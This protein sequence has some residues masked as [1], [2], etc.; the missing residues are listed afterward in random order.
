M[1]PS[2]LRVE[3]Y[4]FGPFRLDLVARRLFRQ[5]KPIHFSP[6]TFDILKLLLE[7]R[8][9][10]VTKGELIRRVWAHQFVAENNL[11]VRMSALRKA[12]GES[13][14]CRFIETVSG[15][16]YRFVAKVHEVL[17]EHGGAQKGALES[18]AVLPLINA[19][20][21]QRLDYICDG[22]T[23]SLIASLSQIA[24]LRV[25]ARSTVF[26][27]K[28]R[29]LDPRQVGSDLGVRAVLSGNVDQLNDSLSLSLE[30]VDVKDGARLWGA[31]YRRKVSDL[32]AFQ[33][34][35]AREV[36]ENLRIR[37]SEVEESLITKRHTENPEAYNLY[38]KGRYFWNKRSVPGVKR[39]IDYF[40]RA[41]GH[42]PRYSLAFAG[43]AD[44]YVVLSNY[45]LRPAKET[46]PKAKE[47]ALKALEL[48]DQMAEAHV[49][50]GNIKSSFEWDW[51]GAEGE[52]KRAVWLNPY[53]APA[54]QYYA[55]FLTKVG[56]I[57]QAIAEIQQAHEIDPL[58]LSVNLTMAKIYHYARRYDEALRKAREILEMEPLFG[59]ANG[60]IGLVNLD[61]GRHKEAIKE[62]KAMLRFSAG[63]YNVTHGRAGK[64]GETSPLPSSDPEGV[65]LMGYAYALAGRRNEAL[66]ILDELGELIKRRYVQPHSLAFV[67]IGLGEKD[68]AFEWLER[69]LRERSSMLT[70]IKVATVFNSVRSDPRY[71]GIVRRMGLLGP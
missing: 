11:T 7:S 67:Y 49:S 38:L 19:S 17:G 20:S 23:E 51:A 61:L 68:K 29:G 45:G 70:L 5:E 8:G 6:K 52:F 37:L 62:M 40:R 32:V 30:M 9:E 71:A 24:N 13:V 35:L 55:N 48:D 47:A 65:A 33:E 22:V 36:S 10:V 16:G 63:D 25:M 15:R 1:S 42:D 12:L 57:D 34:G 69:A 53:Y 60:V 27:F 21:Q 18:L 2:R 44:A 50:M 4:E 26:R 58:S 66:K 41:I 64:A 56:R 39:A 3:A 59:P 14:E 28:G 31:S 43:I 54:R 46:M